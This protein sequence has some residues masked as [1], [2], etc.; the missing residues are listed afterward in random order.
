MR[1]GF[2]IF[3]TILFLGCDS[4]TKS[5]QRLTTAPVQKNLGPDP[6]VANP[7][8]QTYPNEKIGIEILEDKVSISSEGSDW[9]KVLKIPIRNNLKHLTVSQV[10]ILTFPKRMPMARN[11][12]CPQHKKTIEVRIAPGKLKTV[13]ISPQDLTG[14]DYRYPIVRYISKV[15]F[16]N[17]DFF[18]DG[19]L[20][21]AFFNH[22]IREADKN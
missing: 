3:I 11:E 7:N 17:G 5:P 8:T 20:I 22:Q 2:L 15:K 6:V 12:S 16:T 1:I 13:V 18:E 21:P 10:E 14:C 19:N 4:P 9:N